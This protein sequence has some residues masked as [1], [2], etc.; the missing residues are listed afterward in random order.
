MGMEGEEHPAV[1]DLAGL[2]SERISKIRTPVLHSLSQM[3]KVVNGN[4]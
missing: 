1:S 4:H 2:S 3:E